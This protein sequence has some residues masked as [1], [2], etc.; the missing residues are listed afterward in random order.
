MWLDAD[1]GE[2]ATRRLA[3][4]LYAFCTVQCAV[5]PALIHNAEELTVQQVVW[6]VDEILKL[7]G[8]FYTFDAAMR[9]IQGL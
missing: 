7:G 4:H 3:R 6:Y 9:A 8:R 2:A 1:R 5:C